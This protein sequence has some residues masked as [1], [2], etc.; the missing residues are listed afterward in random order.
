MLTAVILTRDEELHIGRAI[1]S[2][3]G[4]ADRVFVVDSG[5]TD[6]TVEIAQG[7]GAEVHFNA[8]RNYA[9]QYNWALDQLPLDTEWVLRLDADEIVTDALRAEIRDKLPTLGPGVGGAVIGRRM[10]FLGR[11]IRH[12]GLFPARMLRLFRHGS[13]RCEERW[14]DEHIK[15]VGRVVEFSGE[16]LDDNRNSLTWWTAKHNSYASREAVDLLNL[17]YGFMAHETV[18]ELGG[19]QAGTK[20]WL[21][22]KVYA[23]LPC[24]LRAFAYFLYRYILRFGL[25]DGREG[26]A[27][28]VLQGFWYRYLVD[29]KV[30]ETRAHMSIHNV[31]IATAIRDVLGI[32]V[33][34]KAADLGHADDIRLQLKN[35][36]RSLKD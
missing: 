8:W 15:V 6:R 20:R 19:S 9:T 18:A 12:G 5:S 11:P 33:Q 30:N 17:E 32:D 3:D 16:I 7:M 24:S 34:P 27:F 25:L 13:G 28:H 31:D 1:R 21:K 2:L 23:R 14:M 36:T 10:T 22:E 26:L 4:I 35:T 29:M